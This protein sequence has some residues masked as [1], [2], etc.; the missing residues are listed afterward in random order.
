VRVLNMLGADVMQYG[1]QQEAL[2]KEEF[3]GYDV[4]VNCILWDVTREDHIIYKE[5]LKRMKKGSLIIDVSCDRN[6]GIESCIPTTIESPTYMMDG[7]MHYAVDHTPSLFYKTFS[8]NNSKIICR[9]INE[10]MNGETGEVLDAAL[11]I[12]DG[13]IIDQ[14]INQFQKR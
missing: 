12:R 14:E 8:Y 9:Y 1:R 11:I 5:D 3:I 13:V 10:L 7:V 6:G 4:V 2:F